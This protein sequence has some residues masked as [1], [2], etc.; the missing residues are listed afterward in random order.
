[1]D[2]LIVTAYFL[3]AIGPLT[4]NPC[5]KVSVK[6]SPP[7]LLAAIKPVRTRQGAQFMAESGGL[8]DPSCEY[9]D[10][11]HIILVYCFF[12]SFHFFL[13]LI[14]YILVCYPLATITA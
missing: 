8:V 13:I 9:T 2:E 4:L 6:F 7:Y 12:Y 11:I 10:F 1:M 3:P 5:P 14:I